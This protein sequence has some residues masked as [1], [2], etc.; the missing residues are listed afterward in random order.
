MEV[1]MRNIGL[2]VTSDDL[3]VEIAR[4][5]HSPEYAHHVG[6]ARPFNLDVHLFP[7]K[8]RGRA[9]C[10]VFTV[11][12]LPIGQQFLSEYG[13]TCPS[14]SIVLGTKIFFQVSSK[15]PRQ[16]IVEEIYR[17]PYDD[18]RARAE[19]ERQS[20]TIMSKAIPLRA[21]QFG[22][23]CRDHVFS[24]EWEKEC[25]DPCSL[26]FDDD[27]REFRIE[28]NG[29]RHTSIIAIRA[30]QIQ[31]CS[32]GADRSEA[33]L[34]LSLT[35][36]PSFETIQ[37]TPS[38]TSATSEFLSA[39]M[40]ALSIDGA[41]LP[42][43]L[44]QRWSAFDD[45][46][47]EISA[48]VSIAI[49][50]VC[51]DMAG[52]GI[53]RELC[54]HASMGAGD[55]LYP[56]EH[57]R[58]FSS[59]V[60]A[61]YAT[62][63]SQLHWPV[64]FQVEA[65]TRAMLVDLREIVQLRDPI[66]RMIRDKGVSFASKF[67]RHFAT[68][69]KTLFWYTEDAQSPTASVPELFA[70]CIREYTPPKYRRNERI[71]NL[72]DSFECLHVSCTPTTFKLDGPYPERSNRIVRQYQEH[73]DCFLRV[74]FVDETDLQY[75]FDREVD[76]RAFIKRRVGGALSNGIDIAG[77]H[78]T[79]LAYSQSAL[80]EHA[81]WFMKEFTTRDGTVVN[82]E[83]IISNLGEFDLELMRC[84]AR[85]GARIS[86]AFTATDASVSVEADEVFIEDDI[87]T[88]DGKWTY[89]DGVGTISPELMK[90]I[91]N[92]LSARRRASRRSQTYPRAIQVR[93][94]GSKGMLS[95]NHLLTGRVICL[96]PSMIKFEA[97]HE[98]HVEIARAFYKPGPF[99]LNR[100]FIMVLEALGVRY[101]VFKELQRNAVAHAQRAVESL[102]NS[103]RL[104][105]A[106]GLG[107]SFKFTSVMLNL[108]KLGLGPLDDNTFW[109]RS[110]DFAINH[111]LRELK[112]HA[113]IPVPNAWNLVGIA[114]VHSWLGE[115]EVFGCIM[116][117]DGTGPIYLEGR[118][119]VSRSPTIHPGDVQ[120]AHGIG[121]SPPGSPFRRESLRNTL[122]FSIKGARPLPTYLGGG[123]LDGD[124]YRVTMLE[125]LLPTRTYPP[126]NYNPAKRKVL[127]RRST[128]EDVADFV[129]EYLTS[130]TL[131][132][133][134][135][136]WLIIAD[137]STEGVFD[138]DC[139]KLSDLHSDAVDYPKSGQPVPLGE[140]PRLKFRTKPDWNA[141]ET[142][143][144]D[145]SR[146]YQSARA[147]G[148]LFREIELP[149]VETARQAQRNQRSN[150]QENSQLPSLED[151]LHSFAEDEP[152]D[153]AVY[154]AVFEHV[155]GYINLGRHDEDVVGELWELFEN[156]R[157]QL[158]TI[159]ADHTLSNAKNAMLTE[160]EAVVGTIVA[161]CSQ[162]RK[163]KDLMSKMRE[164]TGNLVDDTQTGIAGEDGITLGK[165]LERAW[166]AF[167]LAV[168]EGEYETF[169]ARSF[170]WV[171]LSEVFDA[172]KAIEQAEWV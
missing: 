132:I 128:M 2:S 99:Y 131:G 166:I 16:H 73:Q 77:R 56:I 139:L 140:M 100:P 151:V 108:H 134:A 21:I 156:Y 43:P 148:R 70:R 126:A 170:V 114:D 75:R 165:R 31:W 105:E 122:V 116:P 9:G 115:N 125:S 1:F 109:R 57:R 28:H 94:Q 164:Q 159:C 36:P 58:L 169:G 171:A 106:Y 61:E 69:A 59:S 76:G 32:A 11:A 25:F 52:L 46:H 34:Y 111:V 66:H 89:T 90:E 147:I 65:I 26:I 172:I 45:E 93:F 47:A 133:I 22:W 44:R 117:T 158:Q 160:E 67:L 40:S 97:P 78:F 14:R 142:I 85:Y 112:H 27:R 135:L 30:A 39:L 8:A 74:S 87:K 167:K 104:L 141:P 107:A 92:A 127:D 138:K 145:P 71:K 50:L 15:G 161:K 33:C 12:T 137:Q 136:N 123:D 41:S 49:R 95:V 79:F 6:P 82:A 163:R 146:Y 155:S 37:R 5:I 68:Q 143:R 81:V 7:R 157:S 42:P 51:K 121:A 23:E 13:G 35:H 168:L 80:K 53:F 150:L 118:V 101:E 154:D 103:G 72:D 144:P 54:R 96:R 162:P 153:H 60:R 29:Q 63:I 17:M 24:I 98:T 10:G 48:Y 83:Y 91:W 84:P 113:R 110:M 86:Q 149:A 20:R 119:M 19:R 129:T 88:L 4:V 62:W 102:E 3:K 120:I 124:E 152:Q 38:V 64:A 55:Y 18:P 130:D